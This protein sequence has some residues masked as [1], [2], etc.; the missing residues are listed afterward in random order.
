MAQAERLLGG[1]TRKDEPLSGNGEVLREEGKEMGAEWRREIN[2][3][4]TI[5]YRFTMAIWGRSITHT[6]TW[7]SSMMTRG[8]QGTNNHPTNYVRTKKGG[9]TMR[10]ASRVMCGQ[11]NRSYHARR[12]MYPVRPGSSCPIIAQKQLSTRV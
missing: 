1:R 9:V 12:S 6:L 10:P 5:S 8:N 4:S 7:K 2:A 11:I 3:F